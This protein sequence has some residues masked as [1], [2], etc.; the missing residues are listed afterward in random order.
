MIARA[1]SNVPDERSREEQCRQSRV[2][3][4]GALVA[5]AQVAVTW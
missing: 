4:Y 2:K 1:K 5:P 3:S